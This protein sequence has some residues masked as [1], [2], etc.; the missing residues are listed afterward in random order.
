MPDTRRDE[1]PADHDVVIVGGGPA[2]SSAGVFTGRYGLNT[3]VF[4]RGSA[5]LPRCA[6]LENYPGFP[7]GIDVGTFQDLLADHVETAGCDRIEETVDSVRRAASDARFVVETAAGRTVTAEYVLAAAWYDGAYLRPLVGEGAFEVHEHHGESHE[8]FDP[9]YADADGRTAVDGLYVAAPAGDRS[10]QVIVAAGHGAHVARSL[11]EDVRSSRGYPDGV[12]AHYDWL[13]PAAEFEGEWG[14]RDRWRE[15]FDT[16]A[17]GAT[18]VSEDRLETLRTAEIDRA[19]ET[20]RS[21]EPVE[22][23]TESGQ[24]RLLE[25]LDDEHIR[26]YLEATD[27]AGAGPESS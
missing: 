20:K 6:F 10:A 4:D 27:G 2:G 14:D 7:G 8:R 5:A 12:A 16:E 23:L 19:F 21:T 11:L 26:A 1:R 9:A 18:D 24:K 25:H 13:R 3:A 15:W 17:A 22:R